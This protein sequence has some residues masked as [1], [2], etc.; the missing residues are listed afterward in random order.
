MTTRVVDIDNETENII[1]IPSR[2]AIMPRRSGK[3]K[4]PLKCYEANIIVPD[5]N[6]EDP[7]TYEDAMMDTDK[8]KWREVMNQEM[9]IMYFNSVSELVDLPEGFRPI[10]NKWFY[11]R[12]ID[13]MDKWKPIK[14]D[15]LQRDIHRRREWTMKKFFPQ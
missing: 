11:K 1:D 6:D 15:L 3:I 7:S 9:E 14:Q 10:R 5:T 8:E 12:K 13:L 4:K 2:K